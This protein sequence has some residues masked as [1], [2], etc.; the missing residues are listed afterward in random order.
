MILIRVDGNETIGLGHM[1]R[2]LSVAD[3]LKKHGTEVMFVTAD[4]KCVALLDRRGYPH[5][6]LNTDYSEMN[7]EADRLL[8]LIAGYQPKAVLVDS[9]FVT[10]SYLHHLK[11]AARLIYMDDLAAFAYPADVLINYNIFA[12]PEAYQQL[13][14]GKE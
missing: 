10:E 4:D 2:C 12:D 9:Y 6:T 1:M 3:A 13:Y 8:E 5:I 7:S 14:S 11:S